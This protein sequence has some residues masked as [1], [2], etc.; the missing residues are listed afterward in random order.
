MTKE[1]SKQLLQD[2]EELIAN[3]QD[4]SAKDL[5][6]LLEKCQGRENEERLSKYKA[7]TLYHW[8]SVRASASII[9]TSAIFNSQDHLSEMKDCIEYFKE[10]NDSVSNSKTPRMLLCHAVSLLSFVMD[11]ISSKVKTSKGKYN[12][13]RYGN[14]NIF[15]V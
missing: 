14:A 2:W 3:I 8:N 11:T 10:L 12:L 13:S 5:E 4:I 9:S 7:V 15:R 1:D 6:N